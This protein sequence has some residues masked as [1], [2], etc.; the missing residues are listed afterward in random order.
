M[1]GFLLQMVNHTLLLRLIELSLYKPPHLHSPQK[2]P[3]MKE[4]NLVKY[5]F[6][7]SSPGFDL[8]EIDKFIFHL[9]F[10]SWRHSKDLKFCHWWMRCWWVFDRH[11]IFLRVLLLEKSHKWCF[12]EV[13]SLL[14]ISKFYFLSQRSPIDAQMNNPDISSS[15]NSFWNQWEF[16]Q[17]S[18]S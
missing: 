7:L 5:V 10:L 15:H 4:Q 1:S 6:L 8:K 17:A 18:S 16:L 3:Y 11:H 14:C 12:P 13:L 9:I 2:E